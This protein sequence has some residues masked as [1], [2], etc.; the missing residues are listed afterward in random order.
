MIIGGDIITIE[1]SIYG[2]DFDLREIALNSVNRR[3][4]MVIKSKTK[5]YTEALT[6]TFVTD[7]KMVIQIDRPVLDDKF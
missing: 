2:C 4:F 5:G 1:T 6:N 7:I 3:D